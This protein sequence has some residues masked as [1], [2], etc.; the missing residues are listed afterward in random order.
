MFS[1]LTLLHKISVCS[2]PTPISSAVFITTLH[3][4]VVQSEDCIDFRP[5]NKFI[6]AW[7][8]VWTNE[9][10]I[11]IEDV[12]SFNTTSI[13]IPFCPE[14][15]EL[16]ALFLHNFTYALKSVVECLQIL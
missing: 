13:L 8:L 7:I 3:A 16:V 12:V 11:T 6:F 5:L 9:V 15:T 2:I 4:S 14:S 1:W 10:T